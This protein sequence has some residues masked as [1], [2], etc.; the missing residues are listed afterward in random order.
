MGVGKVT[1]FIDNTLWE[2]ATSRQKYL[3]AAEVTYGLPKRNTAAVV[4]LRPSADDLV[5][6][7]DGTAVACPAPPGT[8]VFPAPGV[9][10]VKVLL[11]IGGT[12]YLLR[13]MT[14]LRWNL[15]VRVEHRPAGDSVATAW[16]RLRRVPELDPVTVAALRHPHT[17][18]AL[19]HVP[20][21]RRVVS[22][23]LRGQWVPGTGNVAGDHAAVYPAACTD[24][25]A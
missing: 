8:G 25:F 6:W 3:Y 11:T 23:V 4:L 15:H 17:V 18:A 5:A 12:D 1:G 9:E 13:A 24:P 2:A 16:H 20:A 7:I 21:L 10:G 22:R 14:F 19:E